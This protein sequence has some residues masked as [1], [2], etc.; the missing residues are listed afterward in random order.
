MSRLRYGLVETLFDMV[1]RK[2]NR[3]TITM[4]FKAYS[5][6]RFSAHNNVE[7]FSPL[8]VSSQLAQ[9]VPVPSPSLLPRWPSRGSHSLQFLRQ[10]FSSAQHPPALPVIIQENIKESWQLR[11]G[12]NK[13]SNDSRMLVMHALHG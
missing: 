1:K 13:R 2:Y 6:T 9:L 5:Q 7:E 11:K 12:V 10:L 3:Q 8:P 4:F